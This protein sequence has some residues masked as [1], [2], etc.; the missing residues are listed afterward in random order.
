MRTKLV[1][2]LGMAVWLGGL[3]CGCATEESPSARRERQL[4]EAA[5]AA[6]SREATAR[7]DPADI[8]PPPEPAA[9]TSVPM[10]NPNQER[11]QKVLEA[12]ASAQAQAA[13]AAGQT[14]CEQAFESTV[15]FAA[16]LR[17][18]LGGTAPQGEPDRDEFV[19]ACNALP[20]NVQ[21]CMVMG[22]SVSHQAECSAIR[23]DMAPEIRES[24][25]EL[26]KM[27]GL[28]RNERE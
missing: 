15:R 3:G 13:G 21:Q 24:V 7:V 2:V 12:M 14:T 25:R 11:L 23:R 1:M 22:Y 26:T 16:S 20:P 8:P 19:R 4:E 27:I 9:A 6:P 18:S 5:P 10:S 17:E 28:P